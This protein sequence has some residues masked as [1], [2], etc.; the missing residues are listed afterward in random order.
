MPLDGDGKVSVDEQFLSLKFSFRQGSMY[1]EQE[2][3]D[4]NEEIYETVLQVKWRVDE[5]AVQMLGSGMYEGAVQML[6]SGMYKIYSLIDSQ[7]SMSIV[8]MTLPTSTSTI[9]IPH[10]ASVKVE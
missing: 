1:I 8:I 3:F 10:L 7:M 9:Q 4:E 6:G 5:G 2:I